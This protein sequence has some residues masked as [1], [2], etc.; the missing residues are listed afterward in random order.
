MHRRRHRL[1]F[2]VTIAATASGACGGIAIVEV[3][4]TG[5]G[6][7]TGATS[8]GAITASATSGPSTSSATGNTVDCPP[9]PPSG[10]DPCKPSPDVCTYMVSC[11]SGAVSLSF[12]CGEGYWELE[13]SPCPEPYDSCPGTDYYCDGSWWMPTGTNPPSPCPDVPPPA[14]EVCTPGGMGG[15][16]EHCGY[17]CELGDPGS[18]WTVA[19]CAGDI[20]QTSWAYDAACDGG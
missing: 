3:D 15:V 18:A 5:G 7:S 14:G 10:Y 2:V 19:T 16:W 13:P 17:R 20:G 8:S 6:G 11:Q 9:T 1:P 12:V 4:A